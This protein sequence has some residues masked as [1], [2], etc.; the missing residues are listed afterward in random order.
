MGEKSYINCNIAYR[1][2]VRDRLKDL[3]LGLRY[4]ENY[5]CKDKNVMVFEAYPLN[6]DFLSIASFYL[7]ID[8]SD[9]SQEK[10][11]YKYEVAIKDIAYFNKRPW[12]WQKNLLDILYEIASDAR[13]VFRESN[14]N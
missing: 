1:M 3:G 6:S 10:S 4:I 2:A 7:T 12:E 14:E 5:I 13:S 11:K 8:S 9:K